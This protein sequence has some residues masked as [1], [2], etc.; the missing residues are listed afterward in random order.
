[1]A[2]G[3]GDAARPAQATLTYVPQGG[4]AAPLST[5]TA[6]GTLT[7]R[8]L[9]LIIETGSGADYE[10]EGLNGLIGENADAMLGNVNAGRCSSIGLNLVDSLL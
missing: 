8:D 9:A 10:V 1:M 5:S 4:G 2:S 6:R 3:P 7:G